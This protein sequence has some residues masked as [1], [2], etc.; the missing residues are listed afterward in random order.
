MPQNQTVGGRNVE[1]LQNFS[2]EQMKLFQQQFGLLGPD[3]YLYRLAQG[4]PEL[5]KQMETGALRQFSGQMGNLASRFS[6][7][8]TGGRHSSG[9]KLQSGMEARQLQEQLSA[10]RGQMQ[11]QAIRDLMGMSNQILGQN[12]YDSFLIEPEQKSSWWQRAV[13]G[14]APVAGSA[15]GGYFGGPQGAT[16]GNQLGSAFGQAFQ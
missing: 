4:D 15:I 6:G 11:Q 2:P 8:G 7:A 5:M 16:L 14:I 13:G 1:Y 3:S 12:P 10:Q 9:F